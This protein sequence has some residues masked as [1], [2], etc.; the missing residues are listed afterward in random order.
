MPTFKEADRPITV[1]TPLGDDVLL[2]RGFS[3]L[4]GISRVFAFDLDVMAKKNTKVAFEQLLGKPVTVNLKL[5][6]GGTRFFNGI[7][8]RVSEGGQDTTFTFYTLNIVPQFWLLA[9]RAQSRIFQRQSVPDIL[10]KVL[11]GLDVSFQIQG[12]FEQRDFCVQYRET[13]FNFAS[14]LMEE[15]GIYYFFKHAAG[16]HTM[17]LANTPAG[18]P[19]VPGKT[20]LIYEEV[21]GGFRDED[22]VLTWEK[23]QELRSSKYTLFDH[24]FELPHKHL[25]AEKLVQETV[26]VGTV[27]H[28]LKLTENAKLELFDFPGEYAQRFDGVDKGGGDQ[29]AELQKIFQDNRRTVEIRM[30]QDALPGLSISGTGNCRQ[31]VAGHKF[32]LTRHFDGNGQ[33][34]ITG[35]RHQASGAGDFL[36]GKTGAFRYS[37]G[38]TC[39]PVALPFRPLRLTPRPV[40]QGTQSAVVVGPP[41]EEIFPDKF[42]RVKVQFH[43]DREGKNDPDSSCW[44]RVITPWAGKQWGM[45]HIPRVGQEVIVDFLE[46]DPDQPIIVGSVYNSEMMPP[47]DLPANKTKSGI[48]TRSTLGGGPANFNEIRFEDKKG[49]EQLFIHAEKNQDIEVENDETHSV[50]HDRKKTIDHDETTHVKHDRTETVDHDETITIGSDRTELVGGNEA[51]TVAQTQTVKVGQ[52]QSVTVATTRSVTVGASQD[53]TVGSSRTET[54][55]AS[56]MLTVGASRSETVGGSQS[57]MVGGSLTITTGGVATIT[58]GGATM[59]TAGAAITITAGGVMSIQAGGAVLINAGGAVSL[60]ASAI[61]LAS[62]VTMCAG[63]LMAPMVVAGAVASPVYTPGLGNML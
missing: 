51:L 49:N 3:G 48:K 6:E 35:V 1:T 7:C 47:Y 46:G 61:T 30:Q 17:V 14:R 50:G 5:P 31:M 16:G 20:Q 54:I 41:G 37:N 26:A 9:H 15:E 25:E 10:K 18:H 43:W 28:K 56:D 53:T 36:S 38:F 44:L 22:R 55:G 19:D 13:D 57:Q 58:S 32:T 8:Y 52:S 4:E 62:A 39:I 40:V 42:S 33:Y 2:L 63:I 45:V 59:V 60:N 24:C 29:P 34:V 11:A 12:T 21:A 27:T 23:A